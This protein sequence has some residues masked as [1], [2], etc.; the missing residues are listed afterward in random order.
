MDK[1]IDLFKPKDGNEA[2][3]NKSGSE[4]KNFLDGLNFG[5]KNNFGGQGQALGGSLPGRV[6]PVELTESGPLGIMVEKRSNTLGTAIVSAV[7]DGSQAAKAGVQRGDVLCFAGS[8]GQEEIMY[9]MFVELAKSDQRPLCFEVR[10][11][12]I[13]ASHTVPSGESGGRA[14]DFARKQAVIAAAEARHTARKQQSKGIVRKTESTRKEEQNSQCALASSE[15]TVPRS[16][17]TIRAVEA[18]KN[19]EAHAVAAFGY[20]PYETKRHSAEQARIATVFSGN[21]PSNNHV[22][23]SPHPSLL[24]TSVAVS[25]EFQL[26]YETVVTSNPHDS[27]VQCFNVLRKLILNATTKGQDM[28][29]DE[30]S[31]KFRRVRLGNAKIKEVIVD[32]IGALDLMLSFGFRLVDDDG[33]SVLSFP[34]GD[35]G[36]VWLSHGLAIMETYAKS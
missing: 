9:D 2:K 26:A 19:N 30:V 4:K 5:R 33:D 29:D 22:E 13:K 28:S 8:N 27:V 7:I 3:S 11:V 24:D 32:I 17:E 1:L 15:E 20:N 25:S 18:A 36:P 35:C 31:S 16:M 12:P 21:D 23:D 14:E 10:R 34:A 6:I